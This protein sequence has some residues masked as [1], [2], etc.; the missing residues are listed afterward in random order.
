MSHRISIDTGKEKRKLCQVLGADHWLDFTKSND[1]VA[2]I[3]KVTGAVVVHMPRSL[4][5]LR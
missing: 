2:D 4:P 3:K 1:I 5:P